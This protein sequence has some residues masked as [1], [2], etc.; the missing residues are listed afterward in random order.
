[1]KILITG[2]NGQ[3]GRALTKNDYI[4]ANNLVVT[5]HRAAQR[6]SVLLD[7]CD[8]VQ[9]GQL[10]AR[11]RP[12]V[13]VNCAGYTAV[14]K[15]ETDDEAYHA[16]VSAVANLAKASQQ[17]GARLIHV[18][19]DYV[20]DGNKRS[21]YKTTDNPNPIN[22]Y[23]RMKL[24]AE[25]LAAEHCEHFCIVRTAWLYGDGKNF[26]R[27]ML[28]LGKTRESVRVINDQYGSPTSAYQLAD[29]IAFL[30]RAQA[31]GIYHCV[32]DGEA[33]RYELVCEAYRLAGLS[34]Q[35][36]PISTSEYGLNVPRPLYS[37][38]DNSE[39]KAIGC[40]TVTWQEALSQYI[41]SELA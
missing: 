30:I 19:T 22:A 36:V 4:V 1:M 25:R 7:I 38:L 5:S 32:C 33:S 9:I 2:A 27:T 16:N 41:R 40:R 24:E 29:M 13:V 34:T 12:D 31:D 8:D 3:L 39:L 17:I 11:E 20:F 14:D 21:P 15:C 37:V 10:F 28:E 26:V 23:G 6:S 18:S 35:I